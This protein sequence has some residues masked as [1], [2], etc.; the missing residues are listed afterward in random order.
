[1]LELLELVVLLEL[2]VL[3]EVGSEVSEVSEVSGSEVSGTVVEVS[4]DVL[5]G[6]LS[7]GL[8]I[9]SGVN[10]ETGGGSGS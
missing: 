7:T 10:V 3:L 5:E 1:M 8:G 4:V 9:S 6:S 2:L